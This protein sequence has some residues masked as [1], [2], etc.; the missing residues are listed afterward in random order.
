M[1]P[2]SRCRPVALAGAALVL[3]A[4]A[5]AQPHDAPEPPA[6][7]PVPPVPE[8]LAQAEFEAVM[9]GPGFML[10]ESGLGRRVIKGAPYC[11]DAVHETVRILAD[12]NRIVHQQQSR[13]CRDGEG[14]TR[15]EV[16]RN[17]RKRVYLVDPVA[18]RAWLLDPQRKA[19]LPLGSFG[20]GEMAMTEED[21]SRWE[22]FNDKMRDF[23]ERMREWS[24]D[25][26]QRLRDGGEKEARKMVPPKPPAP[27]AAPQPPVAPAK[28]VLQDGAPVVVDVQVPEI[29][30]LGVPPAVEMQMPGFAPRGAGTV[31]LLGAKTI[32]GLTATGER[33]SWTI[34]AGKIGNEKPIQITHEVWTSPD[35]GLTLRSQDFDPR[36]GEINYR[37]VN[38]KRGEP[39]AALMR[40]P[41]DYS[42][43]PGTTRKG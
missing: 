17:G 7:P 36:S 41:A 37:L 35:L 32:D 8:L 15:E 38:I 27:P 28:I 10:G 42:S 33:T 23:S 26:Q 16:E 43:K 34:A 25:F 31:T 21:R 18:K 11:A 5:H 4:A 19:A 24:R 22:A 14:R 1:S 6:V 39:D 20:A 9:D 30:E 3:A 13:L 2:L 12:G 40:V 29:G